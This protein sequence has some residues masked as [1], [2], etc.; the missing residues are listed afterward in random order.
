MTGLFT[1]Q[2]EPYD[3]CRAEIDA[4]LHDHWRELALDQGQVPLD[5]DEAAYARLAA[6]GQLHVVTARRDGVLVGYHASVVRP[7]LH[8]A[9]TLHAFVDVYWLRPDC[10]RGLLGLRLLREAERSLKARG[11]KK[12]MSGT[13]MHLDLSRLYHRLG[14]RETERLFTKYIGD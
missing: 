4:C 5:K 14:W 13:K 12:L 11:V 1:I 6:E 2:Q 3:T 10:R 7:H 9:G 8:Y